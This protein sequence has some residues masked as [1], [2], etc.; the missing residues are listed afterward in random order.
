ML[1]TNGGSPR[2]R[3]VPGHT[4][5]YDNNTD[6]KASGQQQQQ[7]QQQKHLTQSSARSQPVSNQQRELPSLEECLY[8]P[9]TKMG[10]FVP[11]EDAG[12]E[13]GSRSSKKKKKN[14]KNTNGDNACGERNDEDNDDY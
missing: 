3:S 9:R 4:E 13:H 12:E 5:T 8:G 1:G 11:D 6:D 14:S 7:Q 2:H 10:P